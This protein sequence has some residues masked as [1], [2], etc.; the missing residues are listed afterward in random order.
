MNG[1]CSIHKTPDKQCGMCQV[2]LRIQGS[3][4][5]REQ[6]SMYRRRLFVAVVML[7]TLGGGLVYRLFR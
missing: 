7:L 6:Q 3:E 1:L 2:A 4:W 5:V